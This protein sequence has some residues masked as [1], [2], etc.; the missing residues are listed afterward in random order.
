MIR[1]TACF[2]IA[3]SLL[4]LH[5][6]AFAKPVI[7]TDTPASA[8][9]KAELDSRIVSGL[10]ADWQG[11]PSPFVKQPRGFTLKIGDGRQGQIVFPAVLD[12]QN[13]IVIQ[14]QNDK[15][16]QALASGGT[17]KAELIGKYLVYRG[18]KNSILYRFDADQ[19][20]LREFVYLKDAS[21][22]AKD[23]DVIQWRFEGADLKLQADGSVALTQTID[24]KDE[25]RKVSNNHMAE[26]IS[27]F[28]AKQRGTP[29][30]PGT[31]TRT[32]FTIPKP[33]YIDGQGKTLT[34]GI[35]YRIA[36]AKLTLHLDH[37]A[38]TAYPLWVDPT[39]Q[40]RADIDANVIL[41]G[42]SAGNLFGLP[43][44]SAGDFNGDGIDDINI[45]PYTDDNN[46]LSY[47]G[48]AFIFFGWNPAIQHTLR[49][50][51]DADVILNG[52]RPGHH[53]TALRNM[54]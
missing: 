28:L 53:H 14:I 5:S 10:D 22:L 46:G 8:T 11:S 34:Q 39:L 25:V 31:H 12:A 24:I 52:Q 36:D 45:G 33:E 15:V 44:A 18:E 13:P 16:Q 3:F 54:K 47:S 19:Q 48:S 4:L 1:W 7:S 35:Q 21:A 27:R 6:P 32:L 42:Q 20:S 41:D 29:E 30:K 49:A 2:T 9:S 40:F 17:Y 38:K 23:G 26:R 43:I 37:N 51:I 50:D